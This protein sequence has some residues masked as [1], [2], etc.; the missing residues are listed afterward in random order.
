MLIDMSYNSS[1]AINNAL[2]Q[3]VSGNQ[4]IVQGYELAVNLNATKLISYQTNPDCKHFYYNFKPFF[5]K[6]NYF[7]LPTIRCQV[8]GIFISIPNGNT[9]FLYGNCGRR[10]RPL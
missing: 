1:E 6:K 10:S 8:F 7:P 9:E 5:P 3:T 2:A 4:E